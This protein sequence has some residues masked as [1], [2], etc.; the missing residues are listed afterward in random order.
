LEQG[1]HFQ[2]VT[3]AFPELERFATGA[4]IHLKVGDAVD[5]NAHLESAGWRNHDWNISGKE[6]EPSR[7]KDLIAWV[8]SVG[9]MTDLIAT[10]GLTP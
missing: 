4:D 7:F 1:F 8:L 2:K 9:L 5:R 6:S 10:S 3:Q